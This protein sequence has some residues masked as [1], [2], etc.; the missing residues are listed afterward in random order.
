M[1]YPLQCFPKHRAKAMR[2]RFR[3]SQVKNSLS[4]ASVLACMERLS[5]SPVCRRSVSLNRS[6][7]PIACLSIGPLIADESQA[8]SSGFKRQKRA[9]YSNLPVSKLGA[10]GSKSQVLES[11]G[12]TNADDAD[13]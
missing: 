11:P 4:A 12:A 7:K 8:P 2:R 3:A 1:S 13:A 10:A 5:A 6:L 9:G